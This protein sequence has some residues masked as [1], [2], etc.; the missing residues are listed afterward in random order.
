MLTKKHIVHGTLFVIAGLLMLG[1]Y[2]TSW[3]DVGRETA[4]WGPLIALGLIVFGGGMLWKGEGALS[5]QSL[6]IEYYDAIVMAVGIALLVRTYVIEPFKIP[7]GSMI[8]TLLVG[9]YLFVNKMS[10]GHRIPFTR[11]R[12]MMGDGPARGDIAVFEFPENP[13]K[14]YIKRIVGLPGDRVV[15]E[16][17]RLFI[18]G[19]PIAYRPEGPYTYY[20]ERG[21]RVEAARLVEELGEQHHSILVQPFSYTAD[22]FEQIVPPGHYFVLGDNRDNSNDSR[23]WGYVPAYRLLGRAVILF[24]SWDHLGSGVRWERL[25]SAVE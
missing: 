1:S 17:K 18:N 24:W 25:G 15:Y 19:K 10:Y 13:D 6:V 5:K 20:N 23:F 21:Q 2:I 14:D 12:F 3:Q 11:D 16:D 7:S 22:R 8:P 4:A 9:D